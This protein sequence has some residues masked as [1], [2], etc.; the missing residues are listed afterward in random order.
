MKIKILSNKKLTFGLLMVI[1]IGIA[2]LS[3][4]LPSTIGVAANSNESER[5]HNT[6]VLR[7][8]I[9][10]DNVLQTTDSLDLF[11]ENAACN[12]PI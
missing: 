11:L 4:G 1:V 12:T 3:I 8:Y 7:Y 5:V 2:A 10:T 6:S 9:E